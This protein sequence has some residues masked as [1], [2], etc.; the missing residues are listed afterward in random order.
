MGL[1]ATSPIMMKSVDDY[2]NKYNY[3]DIKIYS[4]CGFCK[5]DVQ[6][7]NQ[8]P[9][10]DRVFASKEKDVY[11]ST[12]S[13][14][15]FVARFE[16]LYTTIN[17]VELIKGRYPTS[18]DEC[19][20]SDTHLF[21]IDMNSDDVIGTYVNAYLLNDEIDDYLKNSRFKIVGTFNSP[22]YLSKILST[23]NLDNKELD[24]VI[25][26]NNSNFKSEYYSSI[27]IRLKD[28]ESYNAFSKEYSDYLDNTL[29]NIKVFGDK[30][31]EVCRNKIVDK[32]MDEIHDGEQEL[33]DEKAKGEKELAKAKRELNDA[34]KELKDGEQK[35]KD[36]E[37]EIASNEQKIHDSEKE[38]N[39]QA[40]TVN[41]NIINI[42]TIS[43][44]SFDTVYT[45]T[46]QAYDDYVHLKE[47]KIS[48]EIDARYWAAPGIPYDEG[49]Y[50]D[51]LNDEP[52]PVTAATVIAA[53][54]IAYESFVDTVLATYDGA[55]PPSLESN[56]TNF[57]TL[58]NA[59]IAI[60]N[61]YKQIE[62]GKRQ[63]ED[64]KAEI[65][66]N[67]KKIEDGWRDYNKGLKE[68]K[69][70]LKEFNEKIDDA[71]KEIADAYD[72]VS[73][74]DKAKW[75]YLDRSLDYSYALYKGSCEQIAKIAMIMPLLFFLVGILVCITTMTRL[76]QEQR[77]QIGIYRALGYSKNRV[78]F[79]YICYA[80]LASILGSI[81]GVVVGMMLF[82]TIIYSTWRLL[83]VLPP[84]EVVVPT[85]WLILALTS[86]TI[87]MGFVT[88]LV[89]IGTLKEKPSE[90]LRPKA[91]KSSKPII[92]ERIKFIW[93]RIS[94]TGKVTFRNIFRYKAR[95][96]MTII[97]VAG[98][99]G[100]LVLGFGIK[101]SISDVVNVQY[102]EFYQYDYLANLDEDITNDGVGIA[103]K[104]IN[105]NKDVKNASPFVEYNS[106]VYIGDIDKSVIV[107]IF[108]TKGFD[109]SFNLL[110]YKTNK[111]IGLAN[112]GVIITEKFAINNNL[113]EG[114][115][116]SFE[117]KDGVIKDVKIQE[118]CKTYFQHYLYVSDDLYQSLFN[119]TEVPNKI[120]IEYD[121]TLKELDNYVNDEN[122]LSVTDFSS[123]ISS[124]EQMIQSLDLIVLVIILTAGSLA[125]V[126]LFN[127]IEVNIAER[128]RE[129][130]T[131]KVLGFRR[132]EV[133]YYIFKELLMLSIFGGLI[134]LILGKYEVRIVMNIINIENMMFSCIV[135]VPSYI[136]A[137][138]ITIVFTVIVL[139]FTRKTLR[140]VSM[141]ESLKSIE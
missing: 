125:F 48:H 91:P 93:N 30:Q 28:S 40:A 82:P 14:D 76:I 22:R 112:D 133:Y 54:N 17:E 38:L 132:N 94:F 124:F 77:T 25:L 96:F 26:I 99:T 80:L 100:L 120:A 81:L 116:I 43:G 55:Y 41:S 39:S 84:M 83:Y 129:I 63:I 27:N 59:R 103:L 92:L 74:I 104:H 87:I 135:K 79:K 139:L 29:D 65:E 110:N 70:A 56:F 16:E 49:Q 95:F 71:K 85:N 72:E 62:D 115:T 121:G 127:L 101:D 33:A 12:K 61:G 90:L 52:D 123:F 64:G 51:A 107:Q 68:Y 78:I 131:L 35:I 136:Y 4:T 102:G 105:S 24:T 113:K 58:Y 45:T 138:A 20:I 114:D 5:E 1:S 44:M 126:V 119:K 73:K 122:I 32:A 2:Y 66:E 141:V 31:K 69:D 108:D 46:K 10:I 36:G 37:A 137:F 109:N 98:C 34:L 89:V 21:G 11:I 19:I 42:E 128:I 53:T 3:E 140:N 13:N 8:E 97:G 75:I 117:S 67:K 23:S 18:D 6:A 130:A 60:N 7:L 118:I 47:S 9:Y 86:F 106:K 50:S 15:I 88:Y 111:E 134:G 57:N